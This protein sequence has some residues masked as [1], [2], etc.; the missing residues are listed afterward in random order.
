MEYYGGVLNDR[1]NEVAEQRSGPC[2]AAGDGPP[3]SAEP[4]PLQPAGLHLWIA[5]VPDECDEALELAQR[6]LLD[7]QERLRIQRF[8]TAAL[9]RRYLTTRALVRTVLSRYAPVPP[10]QWVFAAS[11]H[12]R[13]YVNDTDGAPTVPRF[14]VAHTDHLVVLLVGCGRELGVDVEQATRR[15]PMD[16]ADQFFAASERIALT[17]LPTADR[18]SRFWDYWTLKESYI[19]ARGLGLSIPLDGFSF[20][21]DT[22][23]S[24]KLAID[25]SLEDRADRWR[26][27]QFDLQDHHRLAVCAETVPTSSDDIRAWRAVPTRGAWPLELQ[28][29]R[30]S[31]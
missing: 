3:A 9:Q 26:F 15:A 5:P 8:R 27:W 24:I 18:A 16:I 22:D 1:A 13:P 11:S 21:F 25:P 7:A 19:K 30:R 31:A 14:N 12:G 6:V 29:L 17:R 20:G 10:A 4:L 23:N 2:R 28:C